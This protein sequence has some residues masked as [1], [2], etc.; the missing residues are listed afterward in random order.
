ML[1]CNYHIPE[2]DG[3]LYLEGT[4]P[5]TTTHRARPERSH[6]YVCL[7]QTAASPADPTDSGPWM[8]LLTT[9]GATSPGTESTWSML[10]S[11]AP[12]VCSL[13]PAPSHSPPPQ[14]LGS[15]HL[16][17]LNSTLIRGQFLPSA[18]LP[19]SVSKSLSLC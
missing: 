16:V 3:D 1:L 11:A 17:L 2:V 14:H 10:L 8:L 15:S 12:L 6:C 4:Q 9:I 19:H 5:R 7:A 13:L 18:S